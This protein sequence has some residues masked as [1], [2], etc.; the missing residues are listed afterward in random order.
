MRATNVKRIFQ[1]AHRRPKTVDFGVSFRTTMVADTGADSFHGNPEY[2][3]SLGGIAEQKN[4]S[5]AVK[6]GG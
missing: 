4:G 1:L 5:L 3:P 2:C 6:A